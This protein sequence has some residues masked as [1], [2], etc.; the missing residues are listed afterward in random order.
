M[1]ITENVR[2]ASEVLMGQNAPVFILVQPQLAENMGMVARAMMNCGLVNLRL[3]KPREDW[4]SNKAFSASS[5]AGVVLENAGCFETVEEAIADLNYV[6]CNNCT[7]T[8][9]G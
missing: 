3:V 2:K 5:G 4:L 8:R 7:K 6:F 9:Y 1:A